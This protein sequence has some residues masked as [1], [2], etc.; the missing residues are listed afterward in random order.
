MEIRVLGCNGG[1]LPGFHSVSFLI[2]ERVLIDSGH[3]AGALTME[4]Q[5]R[6]RDIFITHFHLDH[7]KDIAFLTDNA[8]G[9]GDLPIT[10]Y[11]TKDTIAD[12]KKLFFNNMTWPDFTVIN[13]GRVPIARLVAVAVGSVTKVKGIEVTA[14]KVDHS[15]DGAGYLVRDGKSAVV[16][17]GDTGPT[18]EMWEII[19]AERDI[20]AV[21]LE[22]SFPNEMQAIADASGH[23]TPQALAKDLKKL[24]R[25]QIP[26][27]LYHLKPKYYDTIVDEVRALGRDDLHILENGRTLNL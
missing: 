19:N 14:F 20:K 24:K 15:V 12:F 11:G 3:V 4:E 25:G 17:S 21:F 10:I 2:N 27:Y 26:F 5:N 8:V 7:T 1:V 16:F 18:D 22:T 6:V 13:S 9:N 23:F